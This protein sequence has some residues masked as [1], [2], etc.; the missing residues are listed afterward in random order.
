[1]FQ[2]APLRKEKREIRLVRFV[3]LLDAF[4]GL[5]NITQPS[6]EL[7]HESLDD[8]PPYSALSYVWGDASITSDVQ[9]N[10]EP[11]PVTENL[12]EALLQLRADGVADWLWIDAICIQQTDLSEKSWQIDQMRDVY[13]TADTVHMWLGP[14]SQDTDDTMDLVSRVGPAVTSLGLYGLRQNDSLA[15]A[16]KSHIT[17]LAE[18]EG[19]PLSL[20]QHADS[21]PPHSG[22]GQFIYDFLDYREGGLPFCVTPGLKD[23]LGRDYWQRIWII[24]EVALAEKAVLVIGSKSTPVEYFD[25]FLILLRFC[26]EYHIPACRWR[27]RDHMTLFIMSLRPPPKALEVRWLRRQ[28]KRPITVLDLLWEIHPRLQQSH[29]EATDPRDIV[30]GILGVVAEEET[31]GIRADFTKTAGQ[32][33]TMLT[34]ALISEGD[35]QKQKQK[36]KRGQ[37]APFGLHLCSPGDVGGPLPTWA[38]DWEAIGKSGVMKSPIS[39]NRDFQVARN[40][41]QPSALSKPTWTTGDEDPLLQR[42]GCRVD[43]I[44]EVMAPPILIPSTNDFLPDSFTQP[45]PLRIADENEWFRNIA[46]FAGLGS[47]SGPQEDYVWRTVSCDNVFGGGVEAWFQDMELDE[48]AFALA[49]KIMRLQDGGILDDPESLTKEEIRHIERGTLATTNHSSYLEA[50]IAEQLRILALDVRQHLVSINTHRRLFKTAKGMF[51][52]GSDGISVGDEVTIIWGAETPIIL[53]QR[54]EGGFY[55]RGDA[56]VD[57][58]MD[59]EFLDTGLGV[60]EELCLY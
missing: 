28:M 15:E 12:F 16:A 26:F 25:S 7:R 40:R 6:L 9:I 2:H 53:R 44:T 30:F 51:G 49:R 35:H 52:V 55:F 45:P 22:L 27:R 36:Q 58:I 54:E 60:E 19:G 41:Y 38:T 20:E 37:R 39:L 23:I 17:H 48:A 1:M 50:P 57:G 33:F 47:E 10:G 42:K 34:R 31:W 13:T 18:V 11:Y 5:L 59:G 4:Q 24:Q 32:T 8:N 14:G 3:Q 56:Y 21:I 46:A 29:Y 43:V